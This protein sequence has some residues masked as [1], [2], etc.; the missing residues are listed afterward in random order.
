MVWKRGGGVRRGVGAGKSARCV[1][2]ENVNVRTRSV[3]GEKQEGWRWM[4]SFGEE[5]RANVWV[6]NE[7][8]VCMTATTASVV[9][10]GA[11]VAFGLGGDVVAHAH[12]LD[13]INEVTSVAEGED[14]WTNVLRYIT[15]FITIVTGF[16][17]FAVKYVRCLYVC[18]RM[19]HIC[20][21]APSPAV[22]ML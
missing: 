18:V 14:F 9:V 15:F 11:I 2:E 22:V 20:I 19:H 17:T 10:A 6:E 21:Y 16:I 13:A 12:G 7:E 1:E 3:C 8:S 5:E 4:R